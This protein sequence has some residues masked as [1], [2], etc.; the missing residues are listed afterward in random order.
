MNRIFQVQ[1]VA[2]LTL[3]FSCF[4]AAGDIYLRT[5]AGLD[6]SAET[7]FKDRDCMNT[8]P[9][10][11]YGCD[12]GGDEA[13]LRSVG[14]FETSGVFELG[15]G[16]KVS[17]KH[18]F[19]LLVENRSH[20]EFHGRA[21]FLA[22]DRR[23]SVAAD[24]SSLSAMAV[25]YVDFPNPNLTGLGAFEPFIGLGI[26]AARTRIGE[27]RMTFPRTTTVVPGGSE[28]EF[29]WMLTA[30]V[31]VPLKKGATLDF[32]LHYSDLGDVR[33]GQGEGRVIWRDGSRDPLL[34]NLDQTRA[35]L[36]THGIR[37]SIRFEF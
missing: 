3:L 22:T 17:P 5:G 11:L 21:N 12:I 4:A 8:S 31:A 34:L 36:R 20:L 9:A 19:E 6:S 16:Y 25:V 26:G 14:D 27:T 29:A 10:A 18:R 30:G 1:L 7:V 13:P 32:A 24:L 2:V 33:T 37:L 15:L 23:Q 35:R 28:T